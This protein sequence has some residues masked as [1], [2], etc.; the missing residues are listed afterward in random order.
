M[1]RNTSLRHTEYEYATLPNGMRLV[2]TCRP[3]AIAEHCGVIVMAGSRDERSGEEGLAHF[4]EHTLFKGTP[5]RSA[6]H[7]L[8]RMEVIGGELNAYTTKEETVVYTSFP[9]GHLDRAFDLISDLVANSSFP[10]DEVERERGVVL[11]EIDSYLDTPSEAVFDDFDELVY[12]GSP[13]AHNI[14]GSSE[15]VSCLTGADCRRWLER[16]Y[17]PSRMVVFY[18]GPLG[19]DKV[20][21]K[22]ES[23]FGAFTREGEP[24]DRR[25][26]TVLPAFDEVK[27][28]DSNQAHVVLGARIGGL[29]DSSRHV[30]ALFANTLGGPS[31]NSL[32]NLELRERNGW[33]YMTD[34]SRTLLSDTGLLTIYFGCDKANVG[35]CRRRVANIIDKIAAGFYTE[36]RVSSAVRQYVGQLIMAST[37]AESTIL[38]AARSTLY[39]GRVTTLDEIRRELESVTPAMVREAA[40]SLQPL[41]CLVLE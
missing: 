5:R 12:A 18:S 41:S 35:K 28:I 26:P 32:L 9:A 19:A 36:R 21:R 6:W 34:A 33:V 1:T 7:V 8:N 37:A 29:D 17:V 30:M 39:E 11:E 10:S 27:S 22:A 3:D 20:V 14:L 15:S 38:S 25:F 31:M 40:S 13:L 23:Y 24:L 4:V 16:H 2:A